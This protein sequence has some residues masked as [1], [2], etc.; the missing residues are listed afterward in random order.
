[1]M[2]SCEMDEAFSPVFT[3]AVAVFLSIPDTTFLMTKPHPSPLS[4]GA[5]PWWLPQPANCQENQP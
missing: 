3:V 1:M 2:L 4:L 5:P